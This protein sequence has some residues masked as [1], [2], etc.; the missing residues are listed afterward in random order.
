MDSVSILDTETTGLDPSRNKCI[1]VAVIRYSITHHA[2]ID[3][4]SSLII[5]ES[6][7]AESVNKIPSQLLPYGMVREHA[8]EQVAEICSLTDH[9]LA[10]NADFDKQWI[11][12]TFP[13]MKWIDTCNGIRWPMESRPGANLVQLSLDHGLA[14]M[15]PHRALNDCLMIARLLTR[16]A[17]LGFDLTEMLQ[18]GLRPTAVFRACVNYQDMDIAKDN[19]FKWYNP[20]KMWIR[21]MAIEDTKALPFKTVKTLFETMPRDDK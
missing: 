18:M 13:K 1:E 16:V 3:C 5:G 6:N 15:D 20:D 10:H 21:K 19:G 14:V 12:D 11:P 9:V 17:E 7:E 8:W 4:F 2:V